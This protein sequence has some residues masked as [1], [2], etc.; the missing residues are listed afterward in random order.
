LAVEVEDQ[1]KSV[2]VG[3]VAGVKEHYYAISGERKIK[4]PAVEALLT[5]TR[6]TVFP[7]E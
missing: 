6:E 2:P 3:T 1:F 5:A 4:H 7:G